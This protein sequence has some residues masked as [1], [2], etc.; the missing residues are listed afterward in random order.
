MR[1]KI[2]PNQK[3]IV[4]LGAGYCGLH[5]ARN[6]ATKL[7]FKK[8]YQI[9]LIDRNEKQTFASDL[10]EIGTAYNKRVSKSCLRAL[11]DTVLIPIKEALKGIDSVFVKADITKIDHENN[12]IELKNQDAIE[13][14][15]LVVALGSETNFYNIPGLKE[16]SFPMK[17][18]KDAL[19]LNCHMDQIF[20]DQWEKKKF[21][22]TNIIIGGGGFTGVEY[23]CELAGLLKKLNEKYDFNHGTAKIFVA[24]GGDEF[25]GLGKEVS[26][27]TKRRFKEL[28]I[29]PITDARIAGYDGKV[30]N[31]C[32][33]SGVC[34]RSLR[35]DILIWTGGIRP[36][37]LLKDFPI[38][39]RS[40]ALEVYPTL[41][42]PHYPKVYAGGDNAA[43]FYPKTDELVP[44]LAQLAVQQAKIIA[45]NI[46]AD[47]KES[48]K[49]IYKPFI[50]GFI[51]PL[52][53]KYFVYHNGNVTFAGIIPYIMKKIVDLLY[54]ASVL[55][56]K[57][58]LQKWYSGGKIFIGND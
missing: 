35:A 3:N 54:F 32:S 31:I 24:Q 34:K 17:T 40:G 30:L 56:L 21:K 20:R 41:E 58:A 8:N 13:Y 14:E 5:V 9:I 51:V 7:R 46:S 44:K 47:I 36:N 57:K 37:H 15:Y 4:I 12:K 10:Y 52:G 48:K 50:K 22:E 26:D 38:L 33:R 39:D 28:G 45:Y 18:V 6:L 27:I 19:N 11:E 42:S 23:A 29:K 43:I 16:H 49:K 1:R 55:P 2:Q 53:A 25:V